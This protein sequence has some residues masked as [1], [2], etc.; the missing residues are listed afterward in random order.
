MVM[1]GGGGWLG[2]LPAMGAA[3]EVAKGGR[4]VVFWQPW[5]DEGESQTEGVLVVGWGRLEF[6][7]VFA[8]AS[9]LIRQ[10]AWY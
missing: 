2:E 5:L 7:A 10:K 6:R 8:N 3:E 1:D 9:L 4:K